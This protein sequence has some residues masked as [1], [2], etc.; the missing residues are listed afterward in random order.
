[1]SCIPSGNL[2][3]ILGVVEDQAGF[4]LGHYSAGLGRERSRM[5]G[6]GTVPQTRPAPEARPPS[7]PEGEGGKAS[8][9]QSA[10]SLLMGQRVVL[11]DP[12][13]MYAV[14]SGTAGWCGNTEQLQLMCI[15]EGSQ[16]PGHPSMVFFLFGVSPPK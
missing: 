14:L 15:E 13:E 6:L 16:E 1:M 5:Q 10:G 4:P 2:D 12:A 11:K 7:Q 8:A 3:T 9:D